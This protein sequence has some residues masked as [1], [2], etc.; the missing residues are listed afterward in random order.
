[1]TD[2][3]TECRSNKFDWSSHNAGFQNQTQQ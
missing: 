1:M 3:Q 2:R